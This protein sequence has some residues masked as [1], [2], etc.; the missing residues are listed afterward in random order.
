MPLAIFDVTPSRVRVGELFDT[1]KRYLYKSA[2]GVQNS[3]YVKIATSAT[4]VGS[5]DALT[6]SFDGATFF[7][8][9]QL[10]ISPTYAILGIT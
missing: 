3:T 2:V 10:P 1:E 7:V 6:Y 4:V 9:Q 5:G 8:N